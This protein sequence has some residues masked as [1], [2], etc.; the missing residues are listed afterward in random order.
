VNR[1]GFFKAILVTLSF[2]CSLVSAVDRL[3]PSDYPA[4]QSAIDAAVNGDTV[5]IDPNTYTGPGNRDIIVQNKTITIRSIDPNDPNIVAAT[6]IDCQGTP[7]DNH[8]G[9]YF[10]YLSNSALNGLT[11]KNGCAFYGGA[12]YCTGRSAL[13]SNC[14]LTGNAA[15]TGGAINSPLTCRIVID[16]CKITNNT[17]GWAGGGIYTE[18]EP[19]TV[20]NS[21]IANN[22]TTEEGYSGDS[23]GGG[24]CCGFGAGP[25]TI[26]NCVISNNKTQGLGGAILSRSTTIT[27]SAICNNTARGEGGGIFCDNLKITDSIINGNSCQSMGGGIFTEPADYAWITGCTISHN[28][29]LGGGGGIASHSFFTFISSTIVS[30]NKA[31]LG[32]LPGAGI[33]C[34][35]YRV[36]ITNCTITGNM[37]PG[38]GAAIGTYDLGD[39][40]VVTNCII[41]DN[42]SAENADIYTSS[43]ISINF[44][45]LQGGKD[46]VYGSIPEWGPGNIDNDPCFTQA[47]SFDPNS[48]PADPNDDFWVDGDYHL[49]NSSPCINT[50]DPNYTA[51]PN[52][53]DLDGLPRIINGRI[54]MGAYEFLNHPPVANAGHDQTL[55][56]Y[57]PWGA[58]VTLDGSNSSDDDS[59]PGTNDDIVYFNWF[60]QTDPCDPSSNV[61]LG[62]GQILDCNLPLGI[63]TIILE[64]TDNAGASDTDVVIITVQDTTPPQFTLSVTPT[65]LWPISK[66]M[67][68]ITPA[69]MVT[70][71]CDPDPNVSL[72]S[73]QI[74][75]SGRLI[76]TYPGST[77]ILVDPNGP[78][79]LRAWRSG[80]AA[81]RIYTVT[82]QAVDDS[83]NIAESSAIV[84][85][86]HDQRR[87][88]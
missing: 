37:A 40:V 5:I 27:D 57:A 60:E 51:E 45:D 58:K 14:I 36:T 9:F 62:T 50:G 44:T 87:L 12:V 59:T 48:T 66:R 2:C 73:I 56:A 25:L 6:V 82:Y 88:K 77:D 19:L 79:N 46:A 76:G 74:T 67:I 11:V 32:G 78:I 61:F 8:R 68:K 34:S 65:I 80:N 23:G 85:V 15:F 69:W 24:I 83:N 63:H 49:R 72:V 47:G 10:Y 84:T 31:G 26:T 38:Y 35:N 71:L 1:I 28:S 30:G 17:A 29:S 81:D 18:S 42:R 55:E 4:I 75:E 41:R 64:V 70:D 86:P 43:R 7:S 20:T 3:V 22:I 16:N 54:D 21:V 39:K 33:F 52:E 53:T 13:I